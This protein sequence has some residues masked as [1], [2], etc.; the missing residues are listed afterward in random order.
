M[1]KTRHNFLPLVWMVVGLGIIGGIG[2]GVWSWQENDRKRQASEIPENL[3]AKA[4]RRTIENRLLLTG[5][6][7]PAFSVEIKSEVS[8]RIE[9]IHARTGETVLR[10]QTLVTIDDTYLLTERG[11]AETEIAGARL[12]VDKKRGNFERARALYEENL[13]SQEVYA[14]LE[15]D[16]LIAENNL[17]KAEAQLQ[18]V[19]DRL[20]KTRILAP[21]DGT[22]LSVNVSEGQVVVG[23]SSVNAGNV[24]MN[25]ADLSRLTIQ[26]HVNQMDIGKIKEGE[27]MQI[28]MPGPEEEN[29]P[30]R[31]EFIA[32]VA[33]VRNNIKGFSVEAVIEKTDP[34]LRPGMSVSLHLPLGRADEAV[35]VPIAAV[36][37]ES[38]GQRFVWV[39]QGGGG[40]PERRPVVVGLSNFSFAEIVEGVQE[41]EE[42]LLVPPRDLSDQG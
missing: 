7:A 36:F 2:Y 34:R 9:T 35:S 42:I 29:I 32:P 25:F 40:R 31:I 41:G 38:D 23:A 14:N 12:E 1:K 3:L 10:G 15:A 22:I 16:L 17:I 11:R 19:E 6:V 39:R 33:S 18:A 28:V 5:E 30:A 27:R 13:I 24:L 37:R 4:S 8:G 21:A 26:T 20:S